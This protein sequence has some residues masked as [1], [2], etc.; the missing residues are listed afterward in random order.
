[1]LGNRLEQ[2]QENIERLRAQVNGKE[3]TLTT[4]APE[5]RVRIK[6][7]IVDLRAEIKPF[8]EEYWRILERR[9]HA[10][11]YLGDEAKLVVSELIAG[12][13]R[14]EEYLYYPPEILELLHKIYGKASEVGESS[15]SKL[16]GVISLIPPFIN[17]AYE[18]E[19]DTE[20]FFSRHFPTFREWA[21]SL[22]KK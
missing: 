9:A 5:E 19:I 21:H 6:Q 18:A 16:K 4:I 1:M 17:L 22:S 13:S 11:E 12:E 14:S 7:Q 20:Y 3:I 8:E 15:S 2:L 10:I